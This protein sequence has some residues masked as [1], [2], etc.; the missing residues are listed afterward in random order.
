M[1]YHVVQKYF[2]V[3]GV[4]AKQEVHLRRIHQKLLLKPSEIV[5]D[6]LGPQNTSLLDVTRRLFWSLPEGA[7][8][9]F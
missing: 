5:L 7:V 4:C 9:P 2:E 1:L 3:Q 6:L 8:R